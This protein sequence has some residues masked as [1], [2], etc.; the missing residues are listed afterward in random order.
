MFD[1]QTAQLIRGAP[2]LPQ[3]ELERLPEQL[4]KAFA[5]IVAFR[6]RMRGNR[7]EMPDDLRTQ[8]AQFQR[9]AMT[10]ESMV[11]LVPDRPN[12]QAAAF[13][14]AQAYHLLHLAREAASQHRQE[15][16]LTKNG[17][18][19]EVSALL[20]FLIANQLPDA[21]EMAREIERTE[22][23]DTSISDLLTR[24][25]RCLATGKIS[26]ILPLLE[27]E[28][29]RASDLSDAAAIALYRRLLDGL[30]AFAIFITD[31]Q[32]NAGSAETARAIF[33]EVQRLSLA[34]SDW[35]TNISRGWLLQPVSAFPG[36]HH[37]AS[38]LIG[39]TDFLGATALSKVPPPDGI[40]PGVWKGLL[41]PIAKERPFLWTNHL[42]ALAKGFLR[43]GTS[44]VVS[45]PTGAGKTTLSV[46]KVATVLAGGGAVLYLAPTNA[47]VAQL[48]FDL[49]K[50]FPGVAVRDSV[51]AEDI[52]A[53]IDE[54]VAYVKPQIV[55]MTPERC[56][57]L[58][59]LEETGFSAV[60]LVI[61][62]ECHLLHPNSMGQNR[63][64]LDAMFT[65]LQLLKV[66]P[67]SDWLLL[68]AMMANATEMAGWLSERTGRDCLALSL[69]WKP[70]RQARGCLVYNTIELN[71]L[72]L[73][74]RE[75]AKDAPR[76]PSGRLSKPPDSF[77]SNVRLA[78]YG[79]IGLQQT[80][81]NREIQNY[82]FLRLLDTKV[83]LSLGTSNFQPPSWYP[84]PNKNVVA[85]H[86]AAECI[87]L[88]LKALL[89]GQAPRDTV[90]IAD[91]V[92]ALVGGDIAVQ[93][94]QT[95]STLLRIAVQECGQDS[96]VYR[97]FKHAG[98][99]SANLLPAERELVESLFRRQGGIGA[100]AATATLA[101][102]INLPADVVI[103]VGD[104]RYSASAQGFAQLDAHELLNAAGRAGRAGLVAQGLVIVIP[105]TLVGFDPSK[106]QISQKWTELQE[107]VFSQSDQCLS[108][109]DPINHMLD[110]IQDA[111]AQDDVDVRYFLR[112]LPRGDADSAEDPKLF[113][114]STFGYWH[115]VRRREQAKMDA[116]INYALQRREEIEPPEHEETWRDELA[117]RTGISIEFIEAL[118][119]ELLLKHGQ[120]LLPAST[121]EWVR[122]FFG[123]LASNA[124]RMEM[125]FGHRLPENLQEELTQSD[126]FGGKLAECVWGWMSGE[127]LI[128]LNRRLAQSKSNPGKCDAARKFVL[129]LIP[130]LAFASGLVTRI[131]RNHI[132]ETEGIMPLDLAAFS[133]CVKEGFNA[134]ELLALRF[135]QGA[136]PMSRADIRW[137]WKRIQ[138]FTRNGAEDETFGRTRRRVQDGFERAYASGALS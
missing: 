113:L 85:A 135:N 71:R 3:L 114:K 15:A 111:A 105:H 104:E 54:D 7:A 24:A 33:L 12:R 80:W 63:R 64:S 93:L 109:K 53:E 125:I 30:A 37:L 97:P 112:R 2:E 118:H 99:H 46:L 115:A 52:Y 96:A 13:V 84:T 81:Q 73:Q 19:P 10:Y 102:G 35:P 20:L 66:A 1:P 67:G 116:R 100:L 5:E 106:R 87:K 45:F 38:L 75:A 62:D 108:I 18:S 56:L 138:P 4:T 34:A 21:T 95:E 47:L 51:L 43:P 136:T 40:D 86:L 127:T 74:L 129:K 36:P 117:Y 78:P 57:A 44:S 124:R 28:A 137:L 130:D 42:E 92:E 65:V 23:P 72:K 48:K 94:D 60:R 50:A 55:V 58:L 6:L 132:E 49:A 14:A 76:T 88:G 77:L 119:S 101:Q 41:L 128:Q 59:S 69:N 134:P 83:P 122:W 26:D 98:C 120:N 90:S 131:W 16:A 22:P 27:I 126:F 110:K 68:S 79:F 103:I 123:W 25:L 32:A 121:E 61:F 11:A 107:S 39:A 29:P 133:V 8:L 9:M 89:F 17:I 82:T 91:K 70:T 31:A